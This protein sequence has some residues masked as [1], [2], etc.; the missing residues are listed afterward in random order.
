MASLADKAAA[1]GAMF[2]SALGSV[3][4]FFNSFGQDLGSFLRNFSLGGDAGKLGGSGPFGS[5]AGLNPFFQLNMRDFSAGKNVIPNAEDFKNELGETLDIAPEDLK[6][7]STETLL[8]LL[9]QV[10]PEEFATLMGGL[11]GATEADIQEWVHKSTE[12]LVLDMLGLDGVPTYG[13]PN[14]LDYVTE[15]YSFKNGT[16][17]ERSVEYKDRRLTETVEQAFKDLGYNPSPEEIDELKKNPSGVA[18]Y[19]DPRQVTN[20]EVIERLERLG[21]DVEGQAEAAGQTPEEYAEQIKQSVPPGD[22]SEAA[23]DDAMIMSLTS[24]AA[25][26][27]GSASFKEALS[28]M[29]TGVKN[30]LFGTNS[31]SPKPWLQILKEQI[32]K[33]YFPTFEDKMPGF[34]IA[35]TF[36]LDGASAANPTGAVLRL[37]LKIPV[38]LPVNGPPISIPI[39]DQNGNYVNRTFKELFLEPDTGII[40]Q[41]EAGVVDTAKEI[42]RIFEGAQGAVIQVFDEV[43]NVF[44]AIPLAEYEAWKEGGKNPFDIETNENGEVIPQTD[45]N[46]NPATGYAPDT[47]LPVYEQLDEEEEEEAPV[48]SRSP[49]EDGS[50]SDAF[51]NSSW[52]DPDPDAQDTYSRQIEEMF[53]TFG[54]DTNQWPEGTELNISTLDGQ[55]VDANEDGIYTVE[56]LATVGITPA[57]G[58][59]P[60]VFLGNDARLVLNTLEDTLDGLGLDIDDIETILGSIKTDLQNVTT[61]EDLE[62]FR[63]NLIAELTDPDTGLPSMGIDADELGD[64]LDPI[65]DAIGN[66]DEG[67]GLY[68]YISGIRDD[69][70]QNYI[71][72]PADGDT[73]ATGIYLAIAK[74]GA[75][76]NEFIGTAPT[77]DEDGN[78]TGGS[79]LLLRLAQQDVAIEDLPAAVEQIVGAPADGDT[80][81]TG[82]Y[83]EL[84][85]LG[86]TVGDI[87]D[88]IGKKDDGTGLYGYI[89]GIRDDIVQNYIGSPAD[90]DTA[91][92][93][94]YLAIAKGGAALNEFIGTAPTVDEDGNL[95]GGSGLLL[96]LA[97]QDVAIE[98]LPAA[99]EQIVGA[100]AD[101]DTPATGIYKELGAL[102]ITVGD[103][104]DAIGKKD[105]GTGLYG[106]ISG[107]RDDIVQN[108]IGSPADGDTAATG[109]YLAIDKGGAALNEFIGT[110]PTVDEDGNLVG[111]SGLLLRLAQQDVAIEDLP[112]AVE[113]IV[114]AP[115]DGD[116]PATGIYKELGALGITVG[117]IEDAIGKKDDGTGL[118]GYISGIRDDIVQN[119]IGSPAD[120]D[121]AATGIYLAIDK[122]G[123][124]LNE[125]IG[126]APTVDEDGNLV[127]GSGLLLRLAQQDVAIE[128]LP[129]AVE[130]IVGAPADGDTPATGIYKELGALGITVGDIEDAIGK[131]DD[132]TGLY[133]YISGI[134]DDIVQNYIGSPADGDTAATGIYLA[135]DKGGA[136]LNEFIGTAPTVDEDG[137]LVGGS[138]LLLRLAQQDVAIEDLPAA[139]E[140]IVGAP[141]DGDTPATGIYKELGALGITVGDIEDAIGK[142]DDG[143]GLYGYISGIR[144]DIVQN[145]IGSPADGDTAATGIYLAIDKG[146]AALNEFIGTAPTVDE[147]GNLV[148]GSGL[149]LRLAQ[150]DVAIE[151]LPAAVE[152]IVGAPADGDTPATGIYKELGALGI[153]VG[154]IEDAIGKKDDGTGLYGYI[155]GIRDDI[156][157]NYIGE[158]EYGVDAD[159]NTTD[160]IVGGT[161]LYGVMFGIDAGNDAALEAFIGT[162]PT[163]DAD[164]NL[165]GGSG[166]LLTLAQQD[167]DIE[168]LPAEVERIV[169]TPTTNENGEVIG[170]TGLY[171][172]M[173]NLGID[174]GRIEGL[175]GN[176]EDGNGLYGVIGTP[177]AGDIPGTGLY[178]YIDAAVTGLAT[179][180]D[181]ERIV[182]VPDIDEETGELTDK[183]TGLYLDFYNAGVDYDTVINLIGVP[184]NPE[185]EDVNEG[186]GLFGYVGK[187]NED[188]KTYIDN[189][190]GDVPGQ[191][192]EI[193]GDVN[194]LV[195]YV[196]SP[197]ADV[198]DPNTKIDERLPTG[199]Y[200]TLFNQGVAIDAIPGIIEEIVGVP[201]YG[202]DDDGNPTDEIVGGTGLYGGVFDLDTDINTVITTINDTVIPEITSISGFLGTPGAAVDDPNTKIDETL[203]TGLFATIE[204]N[205]AAGETERDA[206]IDAINTFTSDGQYTIEQVLTAIGDSNTDLKN[207]I[208]SPGADVD[209]PNTPEDETLPTGIYEGIAISEGRIIDAVSESED[210]T[211]EYLTYIS[212]IIGVPAT[213]LTQEDIDTVVGL[214]GE[215]E[216]ITEIN[217]DNR[218]YDVNFDGVIN[219]IDIGI[220]QGYVEQG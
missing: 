34:P 47:G 116:T 6:D 149:L 71:G 115:A 9:Q 155:S 190:L 24:T 3:S 30:L 101:G 132:G 72:S 64:A 80:P 186:R 134:R 145:Y 50:A 68:G 124:A 20:D 105:D 12:N 32:E 46:G 97:Q 103:I 93:G 31:G 26:S 36:D 100:P 7:I 129:A 81:A 159:G 133:G 51:R 174:V 14:F 73:A 195:E 220:L 57:A 162:A 5:G 164:G 98:D 137:N 216:A 4:Y 13:D 206:I 62:T 121:T 45:E 199:L 58:Y 163:K 141:A 69:I 21:V 146:G 86:I 177:A 197:G 191:V 84:G 200:R 94:I 66:K 135:I 33:R 17:T 109:I 208:G 166:L 82:I 40:R 176:P 182:G 96:R 37:D 168:D 144:D 91:A 90:G 74:G 215:D 212:Q 219:D 76:L 196:G 140:Q 158:P 110:A 118:Y 192:T 2:S 214:I 131:K 29:G 61:A 130:Q 204:A 18:E 203:P 154:D 156:V 1:L 35:L 179:T 150:Q 151:D 60:L 175:I 148:G 16:E 67:T 85:A 217:N 22:G 42:G 89:S 122:G 88:A 185:T 27:T 70:V 173:Y 19:V 107:I 52:P 41:V 188:V 184:D 119:Y 108:Y 11:T 171:G 147:D 104:E 160:E 128:D 95:V 218:L 112:A 120:G 193:Q 170:G 113:Q 205:R 54:L 202:V 106:Y 43:G 152:Q 127:G 114:G 23:F 138:G 213:E 49:Y 136:A 10:L 15:Y 75:A 39:F 161:G 56:E 181:V 77:V 53:L 187:S 172:D 189:L 28:K 59:D 178:G 167:V 183:S 117:D 143:T 165:I 102:G 25:G 8:G 180:E 153:T 211:N 38:P 123:A 87:E 111:G 63:T 92:T 55:P 201:E 194:T 44:R 157:Q 126:T 169:G 65:T 209:D 207:F 198:D 139:V 48:V 210:N 83:K 99:V 78:L 125:F 79:G 142:K